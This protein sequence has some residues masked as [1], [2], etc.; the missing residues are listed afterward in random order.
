MNNKDIAGTRA[1]PSPTAAAPFVA[2]A[3][4]FLVLVVSAFTAAT[5]QAASPLCASK[6]NNQNYEWVTRVAINGTSVAIPKTG[7][8][9]TTGA[10]IAT[11]QAG[12]SYPVEVDVRTDGSVYNEYVKFWFDLNQDGA[13][14]DGALNA[15]ELVYSTNASFATFRTFT[16]TITIPTTAY[17]GPMYVRMIMQYAASP[18]LCG[19]YT[20]GTTVDLLVNITGATPNPTAPAAPTAVTAVAGNGSATVSFTPPSGSISSYVV[21]S[22][23]GGITATGGASPITVTGLANGTTYTFTVVAKAS[24]TVSSESSAPSNPVTPG[25]PVSVS[26][27]PAS[28]AGGTVGAAYSQAFAASGGTAPYAYAVTAGSLPPG[29]ALAANGTLSGTPTAAGS[30]GFTV[31][32]TDANAQAGTVAASLAIAKA[33]Q[34]I[35]FAALPA[36]PLGTAPFGVAATGGASGNPV[37]FASLTAAVCTVAGNTV[38]IV[39]TGTCTIRAS[40]AGSSDYLAAADADQSFAVTGPTVSVSPA[41][42][43]AATFGSAYGQSFSASGA[44]A[45]YSYAVTAGALPPGLALAAN[46]TLSGTPT[47]AGS[48]AFT[49]TASDASG[50]SSGGPFTGSVAAS[51]AVNK[52]AQAITFG[53]LAS[54]AVGAAPIALAATGGASGNAVTFASITASVC[55]VSGNAVT[56]IRT[57]AC[58][59]RASQAGNA[60]YLAAADVDQGFTVS[61]LSVSVSPGALAGGT[62]DAPVLRLFSATGGNAPYAYAITAGALPPGLALAADGTLSGTPTAA[63]TYGFTVTATDA[64][65]AGIGGPFAGSVVSGITIDKAGQAIAFGAL[66]GVPVGT[67]PFTV[68]ATGGASGN[69]VAFASLTAAVC[70]VSGNTVTVIR[71]GA[72]T[73]R[74]SQ[75]GDANHLAAASVDQ[76]FTVSG[77]TVAVSPATLPGGTFGTALSRGF[78]ASGGNGPYAFA[79]TAGALPPGLALAADG[80]LSGTPAAAGAYAFTVTATDASPAAMGGPFAGSV[81]A[82][83]NI[84]KAAQAIAFAPLADVKVGSAPIALSATGGA[85]GNA[86]TFASLTAP[87]CTVSGNAVTI[88]RTGACAIRASQAG[89]ADYLAAADVD[90]GFTVQG[91]TVAVAPSALAAGTHDAAYAQV[92]SAS[93]GNAPYA[94]AVTA[95]ALPP[96]VTLAAN[97]TLSGKPAAAGTYAFTVAATDASAAAMGGPFSGTVA[98]SLTV[99]KAAQAIGFAPLADVNVGSAPVAL[100]A[101]GGASGN[102]VT[103]ASLT[104]PVCTVAGNAVTIIRTGTCAIRASQAG[105]ANY[106]AA[107]DVDRSFAV[108]ALVVAVSPA[109]L[110]AATYDKAFAQAFAATGGN[111]PYAFSVDAGTLPPG[112]SLAANGTLSGKPAAAG[113]Y[114]FTVSATDASTAASGGPF[115]GTAAVTLTVDKAAQAI[116]FAAPSQRTLGKTAPFA[117]SATGGASGKPVTFSSL[118]TPVCAVSGATVTL[119]AAGTCTLAA[120]QE[121][122]ANHLPAPQ[123][124]QSFAVVHNAL[125]DP[126]AMASVTGAPIATRVA[127]VPFTVMGVTAPV[128]IAVVNGEYDIGCTGAWTSAPGMVSDGQPVCVR[129]LTAPTPVTSAVTVVN[130]GEATATFTTTTDKAT[131]RVEVASSANPSRYRAAVTFTATLAGDFDALTGRVAFTYGGNALLGCE[132]VAVAAGEA[133][134]TTRE[135]P[136]GVRE[137]RAAYSG[138]ASYHGRSAEPLRHYAKADLRS[139]F[140]DLLGDGNRD[141][142]L[143]TGDGGLIAQVVR[144]NVAGESQR[145]LAQGSGWHVAHFG[146]FNRDGQADLVVQHD[147]GETQVWLMDG[148]LPSAKAGLSGAQ[149]SLRVALVGDFDGDGRDD[150][151]VRKSDGTYAAWLMLGAQADA[152]IDLPQAGKDLVPL[153]AADFDGDG[154]DDLVLAHADGRIRVQLVRAGAASR[155]A[156]LAAPGAGFTV[157]HAPDLDGDGRADILWRGPAGEIAAWLMDGTLVRERAGLEGAAGWRVTDVADF[158]GSRTDDLVLVGPEGEVAVWLMEGAARSSRLVLRE[159]SAWTLWQVGDLDFDGLPDLVFANEEGELVAWLV[160]AGRVASQGVISGPSAWRAIP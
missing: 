136:P 48:Y 65:G 146:D 28:P 110:P 159:K 66:A 20:Y 96:G 64:S 107:A 123:V 17:N 67:A 93:G 13:I 62:Y 119:S 45:P 115:S 18:A 25:A 94:Y 4:A 70:T 79:V 90:R 15:S 51:L 100:S 120:D 135:L 101:T 50:A 80:T 106:L 2:A 105:S 52:A 157:T 92:F 160:K 7:Y 151:L 137:L 132:A 95:G 148:T 24:A 26:V 1:A 49:V 134:C 71:T 30:F 53:P 128:A 74:A 84:D 130:V 11:L 69:P 139:Q 112:V 138:D 36:V 41:S 78:G 22:S 19:T 124:K 72:C 87:V 37:S 58:A 5:A 129:Q 142:F 12:Q 63:G 91:L 42:L 113:T 60:D 109:T 35:S 76:G 155:F 89:S 118:T 121:G 21:T 88:I 116:T 111:A 55:T 8:H 83:I 143:E 40:Q 68:S 33:A 81:S 3:L 108:K 75:A 150:L 29:L 117:V 82:A 156:D 102:P 141:L 153:L 114:A 147:N 144:G 31:R 44:A 98:A 46:G 34:S 59:I 6:G 54:V 57:G 149:P 140:R 86:V 10:A 23:P 97:G 133:S 154:H 9:D 43:P 39:R 38:T 73:I 103:F 14:Q 122:D 85:S 104:A 27:S 47:A 131:A 152:R 77:L 127:A 99:E 16:G 126:I 56:V 61:G 145:L 158:D 125:P 32:A